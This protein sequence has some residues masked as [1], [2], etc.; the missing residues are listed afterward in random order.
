MR[1]RS[2]FGGWAVAL[3]SALLACAPGAD[4]DD[5]EPLGDTTSAIVGGAA[6]PAAQDAIVLIA[7]RGAFACTGTLIAPNLVLTARHCVTTID[8]RSECGT[9]LSTTPA[10]RLTVSTGV[11]ATP[12]SF[13]ARG[14][15]L[16]AP[17]SNELCSADV[18]ALALDNDVKGITPAKVSFAAPAP[19]DTGTAIG[20]GDDTTGRQQR[21][22]IAILAIGPKR[23]S[24]RTKQGDVIAM[25]PLVS[26][27]VTAESTCFGDSGGP[28]LDGAGRVFAVASRGIDRVC[29]DR[30]TY[31]T[32]L[33]DHE[34]WIRAAATAAGHPIT[35]EAPPTTDPA[36]TSQTLATGDD[37][38]A[39][40]PNGSK[41]KKT[42]SGTALP[43]S[44]SGCATAPG[45]TERIAPAGLLG[46]A[47]A[48]AVARRRAAT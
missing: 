7:D 35:D 45:S 38:D 9:V 29:A 25:D 26:E 42:G 10:T 5:A 17:P 31:W 33:G 22:G 44:D 3:G 24:Y 19:T 8:E 1:F 41:K 27:I 30:P 32:T 37:D 13:V 6:S 15:V 4:A 34:T 39:A 21:S 11:T 43:T 18:V 36:A 20:Y 14:T 46:L 2:G 23:Y 12:A 48:L 16:Y 40:S 47:L 28:L